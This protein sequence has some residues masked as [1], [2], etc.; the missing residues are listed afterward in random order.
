M[1]F[2]YLMNPLKHLLNLVRLSL[3]EVLFLDTVSILLG[4]IDSQGVD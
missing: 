3:A 2:I 4:V 1:F